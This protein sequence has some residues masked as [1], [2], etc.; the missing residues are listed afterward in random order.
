MKRQLTDFVKN[1][2]LKEPDSK[3][4]PSAGV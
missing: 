4:K 2:R 3:Q 1:A